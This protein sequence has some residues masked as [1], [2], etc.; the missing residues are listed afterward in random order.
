[1]IKLLKKVTKEEF[2]EV[3]EFVAKTSPMRSH[4]DS[5]NPLERWLWSKKK[6]SIQNLLKN[7]EIKS[8]I[9][10]G[11]GDGG[12]LEIIDSKVSYTG[13][14]ISPTQVNYV[15]EYIKR[16]QRK[17]ARIIIGDVINMGFPDNTFDAALACD[18]VEHVLFPERL[19]NEAK[20]VVK[21]NGY[22]LFS[23]PH[24]PLWQLIRGVLLKFPLR[25][26]DHIN[27][28]YPSDIRQSFPTVLKEVFLPVG[29]SSYLSLIQIFLVRNVK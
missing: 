18:V 21:K 24:E 29:F 20:R 4:Y 10:L 14:D 13:I 11:C 12:L 7:L 19:F 2:L 23:I 9:D 5:E 17:H 27:A 3:N 6:Q 28:V 8:I 26:P 16:I 22:I 1:M 25:S 15:K